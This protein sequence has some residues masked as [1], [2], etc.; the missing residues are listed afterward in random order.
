MSFLIASCF[1]VVVIVRFKMSISH[2]FIWLF[3]LTQVIGRFYKF[4]E[5]AGEGIY[6]V[7]SLWKLLLVTGYYTSMS[8]NLSGSL[9]VALLINYMYLYKDRLVK[10]MNRVGV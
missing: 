10:R 6:H 5:I 8:E 2:L 1:Y 7:Y 4:L 9:A 3:L